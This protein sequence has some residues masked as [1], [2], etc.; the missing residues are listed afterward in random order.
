MQRF[1]EVYWVIYFQAYLAAVGLLLWHYWGHLMGGDE[2]VRVYLLA[3]IF[4]SAAGGSAVFTIIVEA[5]GYMV[6]LIPA[7][8]K[9][10]KNEGREEGRVEGREEGIEVGREEG[11]VKGR[12]EGL[13]KG[14]E[15]GM[16]EGREVGLT[17]GRVEGRE[18]GREEGRVEGIEE[19]QQVRDK[20]Y[21]EAMERFGY[22]KNGGARVLE[23]T[24]EVQRF[25]D[26]EEVAAPAEDRLRR[27]ARSRRRRQR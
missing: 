7:R 17:E 4:G 1:L 15:E 8:I 21:A 24:P 11:L 20:R 12:E 3:A 23:F 10:L 14:R 5:G 2:L 19:G 9:K 26:G 6:L 27:Y 13:V 25:L 18:E 16:A 22:V